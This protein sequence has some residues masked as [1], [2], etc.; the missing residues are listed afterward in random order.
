MQKAPETIWLQVDPDGESCD[1]E[2]WGIEDD[3]T[4]CQDKINE[5]DIKYVR[6]DIAEAELEA[7]RAEIAN[8][9][10]LVSLL[11]ITLRDSIK[12]LKECDEASW[13]PAAVSQ[14]VREQTKKIEQALE[15][16]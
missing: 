12:A 15:Q 9:L 14:I 5:N 6:A 13:S 8:L 3:A 2:Q 1:P 10:N 16:A 4:W 11:K 7:A